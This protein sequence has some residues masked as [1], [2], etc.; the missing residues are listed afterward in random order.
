[1]VAP[2]RLLHHMVTRVTPLPSFLLVQLRRHL[3]ERQLLELLL[4]RATRIRVGLLLARP[5]CYGVAFGARAEHGRWLGGG[6]AIVGG[7]TWPATV[8]SA[9]EGRVELARACVELH[10]DLGADVLLDVCGGY[11]HEA[12]ARWVEGLVRR[13]L[14]EHGLHAARVVDMAARRGN[15]SSGDVIAADGTTA[16]C[17]RHER[18]NAM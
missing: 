12:A 16:G 17:V 4:V 14:A 1:M 6:G 9:T 18:K 11:G 8:H 13:S 2:V 10:H 7:A 3:P 5:A 15:G